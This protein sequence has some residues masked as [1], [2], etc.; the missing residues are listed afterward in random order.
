M[1]SV[2]SKLLIGLLACATLCACG[3]SELL[4]AEEQNYVKLSIALVTA[5]VHASDTIVVRRELDSVYRAFKTDSGAYHK[6]TEAFEK[7][8]SR[9]EI[10]FRAI[11]D[12]LRAH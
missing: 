10:V 8:P 1:E 3:K 4:N 2:R 9:A 11:S 7:V 12:S 6:A 5:R